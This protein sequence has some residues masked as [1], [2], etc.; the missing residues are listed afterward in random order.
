[1]RGLRGGT[2]GFRGVD[3]V[4]VF[5]FPLFFFFLRHGCTTGT[6]KEALCAP[7]GIYSRCV[8]EGGRTRAN[9]KDLLVYLTLPFD[10]VRIPSIKVTGTQRASFFGLKFIV[11]VSV[12]W[13]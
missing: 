11:V 7:G 8:L 13:L 1:M 5:L 12:C 6:V 2:K 4:N 3:C 10:P 9:F